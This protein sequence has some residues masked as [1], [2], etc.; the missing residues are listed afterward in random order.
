MGGFFVSVRKTKNETT[1]GTGA[2]RFGFRSARAPKS[3]G[4]RPHLPNERP[5]GRV[6]RD[7]DFFD[8]ASSMRFCLK[9]HSKLTKPREAAKDIFRPLNR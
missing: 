3:L 6:R 9:N 1:G 7:F 8:I 4:A 2:E 5:N